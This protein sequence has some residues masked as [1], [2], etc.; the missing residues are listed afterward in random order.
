M[1]ATSR[2]RVNLAVVPAAPRLTH[3]NHKEAG[4]E[5]SIPSGT[6]IEV[7]NGEQLE[8]LIFGSNTTVDDD[9]SEYF[10][11]KSFLDL[12]EELIAQGGK[13]VKI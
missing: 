2:N 13:L 4:Y 5:H 7:E 9:R 8:R 6:V 10:G 1:P 12:V 3:T 11:R